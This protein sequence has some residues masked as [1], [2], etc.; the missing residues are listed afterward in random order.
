LKQEERVLS[1][2]LNKSAAPLHEGA[3]DT[4][5]YHGTTEEKA[6]QGILQ[7]GIQPA[8]ILIGA[9]P[10]PSKWY[11]PVYDR[12]YLTTS[13]GYA[14]I[15]AV[16]GQILGHP[17]LADQFLKGKDPYG[18]IFEV[19]GSDLAG[20]VVPDEDSIAEM[21]EY[22]LGYR[23]GKQ[24]L[25]RLSQMRPE[26]MSSLDKHN[27]ESIQ[28]LKEHW[29]S[30]IAFDDQPINQPGVPEE[31]IHDV[32]GL[33]HQLT[34]TQ[35]KK[36]DYYND[37]G[38]LTVIGKKL[39]KYVTPRL[40][41]WLLEH[42]AHAAHQGVVWPTRAWRLDKRKAIE[43]GKV[44]ESM[45][46]VPLPQRESLS[47]TAAADDAYLQNERDYSGVWNEQETQEEG[48]KRWQRRKEW[49]TSLLT[50]LSLGKIS[51]EEADQRDLSPGCI[52]GSCSKAFKPLPARLYHVTTAADAV[53]YGGIKTR[54]ELNQGYGHGLGGGTEKSISF[55]TDLRIA[56]DIYHAIL[57]AIR[58]ASGRFT[59]QEMLETARKGE[60]AQ[61]EWLSDIKRYYGTQSN[62]VVDEDGLP[63]VLSAVVRGVTTKHSMDIPERSSAMGMTAE[64]AK[65]LG[66][67]PA[68]GAHG[69]QGRD[70]Q[71]YSYFERPATPEEKREDAFQLFKT[72]AFFREQ[73]GGR[74]DPLFFMS[75]TAALAQ[76]DEEQVAVLEFKPIPGAM[77]TQE[78][79]LGEWRTYT[80]RAVQLVGQV[81]VQKSVTAG[82]SVNDLTYLHPKQEMTNTP[83][84]KAWFRNSVVKE[85]D[86]SPKPVY[87][88][89]THQFEV[90]NPSRSDVENYY[91]QGIYFT[92]SEGDVTRNYATPTG[93]D[94]TNRIE[95][96]TD[97]LINDLYSEMGEDF[98]GYNTTEYQDLRADANERAIKEIVGPD[99]EGIVYATYLRIERPV[100][101]TRKGGTEFYINY[102][103]ATGRESGSG[104]RLYNAVLKVAEKQGVDGQDVWSKVTANGELYSDFT[105]YEFEQAFRNSDNLPED[106]YIN[107]G[108]FISQV[109]RTM[110]FDGIIQMEPDKQF[111]NMGIYPGTHHY[112]IWNPRQA[113][114][115][116][117]NVGT[118]NPRSPRMTAAEQ[119][120]L[121]LPPR[122]PFDI[123][124][125]P[126]FR[127]WFDGSE[128]VGKDGK[129][130][131]VYH[132]TSSNFQRF[133]Q[134]KGFRGGLIFFTTNPDFASM[135]SGVMKW[136]E[137][138][139]T[140]VMDG[141]QATIGANIMPCY[142]KIKKL[143]DYRQNDA[144][145]LAEEY[146]NS[147]E[148][149][150]FDESRA[151]A[152]YYGVMEEELTDRQ[153]VK[154]D[155]DAFVSQVA[156]G[157][158]VALE[159][160]SFLFFIKKAGYDGVALVELNALN[161]GVFNANQIKS[162]LSNTGEFNPRKTD[163]TAAKEWGEW[164]GVDLDGTLAKETEEFDPLKIGEP[165][166]AMV[167]KIKAAI[168][169][170]VE[171]KIF[172]ARLADEKLK[173][174]IKLL[175]RVWT[176][177]HIGVPLEATNEKDPGTVE[178]WDSNSDMGHNP[179]KP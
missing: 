32:W 164:I 44:K 11:T 48:H 130:L 29:P 14:A 19:R 146:F 115:A 55:T 86:G 117:K 128:I 102:N 122:R 57:I 161:F 153:K 52:G 114:S 54:E 83:A 49:Q 67:V 168:E 43:T 85:P 113:K 72:W 88:G 176:L 71:Y 51:P 42:G 13:L 160:P 116:I 112:I 143:F 144:Q 97:E 62:M 58:V 172:T 131:K 92:D 103:E 109:Y 46:E 91:G 27:W 9:K 23:K 70:A 53:F 94:I 107:A 61:R 6:A 3:K 154:Y 149:D 77:G 35:R 45:E 24:D 1:Q 175:V 66:Y 127:R 151:C 5:F 101:V 111:P 73:A 81:A 170:G 22:Y 166:P 50:A 65:T 171:V 80:G 90:F 59:P 82:V 12:V 106:V 78:S 76:T 21:L 174:K 89:S 135:Y 104:M 7:S 136:E 140:P 156:K 87:H 68:K 18:Y 31:I 84:F 33:I 141:G 145:Y 4:T 74:M 124:Q 169:D 173:D 39:Q 118:F 177:E 126:G 137:E 110:G 165:V 10:T 132:G 152:D 16:G 147:G 34:P 133:R 63:S 60:G 157:S 105:A 79:A 2:L 138:K 129:P 100:V 36:L 30:G 20:D 150:Q 75:D 37:F 40:T 178:I 17:N 8:S 98:P 162:A 64:E 108:D 93:P 95:R 26:Q 123:T 56:E 134:D 159:L 121:D 25:E 167:E 155:A 163:I 96:R 15:N 38:E 142:L 99:E 28:R 148:M 120:K 41:Q 179:L 69:W 158:W 47:V 119:L 139:G 125:E